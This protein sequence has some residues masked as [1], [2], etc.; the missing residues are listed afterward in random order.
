MHY[1]NILST[2]TSAVVYIIDDDSDDLHLMRSIF[3]NINSH[4]FFTSYS[5]LFNR[6]ALTES[7]SLPKLIISDYFLPGATGV[8]LLQFMKSHPRYKDITVVLYSSTYIDSIINNCLQ[9]GARAF[10]MKPASISEYEEMA[11][12]LQGYLKP[13]LNKEIL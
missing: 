10:L 13:S 8:K 7:A 1:S 6:L 4:E 11:E 9:L 3:G 12:H 5:Q 2:S